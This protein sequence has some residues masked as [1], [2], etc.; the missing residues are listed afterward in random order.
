MVKL[1]QLSALVL[2]GSL[3]LAAMNVTATEQPQLSPIA[4]SV[5]LNW[6]AGESKVYQFNQSTEVLGFRPDGSGQTTGG[7][8]TRLE[9]L[10]NL[11]IYTVTPQQVVAG[12]EISALAITVA[13]KRNPELE[14]LY[15]TPFLVTFSNNGLP[16]QFEF[17][18]VLP[19]QSRQALGNIVNGFQWVTPEA[20]E[21]KWTV[22]ESNATG[23]YKAQYNYQPVEQTISK[24][25]LQ[26]KVINQNPLLANTMKVKVEDSKFSAKLAEDS[27]WLTDFS[28]EEQ[29]TVY[30]QR[31]LFIQ[32]RF[33]TEMHTSDSAFS[34][35]LFISQFD[36]AKRLRKEMFDDSKS[37]WAVDVRT[38]WKNMEQQKFKKQF[39]NVSL[40][41]L[42]QAA[43]GK[44]DKPQHPAFL[45]LM[46]QVERYLQA[47]PQSA[48][49]VP[50]LLQSLNLPPVIYLKVIAYLGNLGEKTHQQSLIA[51]MNDVRLSPEVNEQAVSAAS[52]VSKA[53]VFLIDALNTLTEQSG[54]DSYSHPLGPLAAAS[55]ESLSTR[56]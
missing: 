7:S 40:R 46:D 2:T 15:Q 52:R 33:K 49:Q 17:P 5:K 27:S 35:Q 55:L 47:F 26:Y 14:K 8:L 12:F 18:S 44:T 48:A 53:E 54:T 34:S 31:Q 13:G 29:L 11:K 50:D 30:L 1:R 37:Q 36:S 16:K 22:D 42:L 45:N 23:S 9:G 24:Q 4:K 20:N 3:G 38:I 10:L 41:Q 6:Q 43:L 28:G 51:I 21:T 56:H 39:A 19:S 25:R 32:S